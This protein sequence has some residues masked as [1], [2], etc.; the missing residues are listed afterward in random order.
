MFR[1]GSTLTEQLLAG[2]PQVEAGGE[3]DFLPRA[4]QRQLTPFPE[5]MASASRSGL[6]TLAGD[7]S[8]L[9]HRSFPQA[10][11]VTDKRPDNFLYIGLIM[12]LFLTPRSSTRPAM[13]ST[14][15]SPSTF[16][17]WIKA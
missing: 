9:L 15:A 17:I 13:P 7:Y 2:H 14:T 10:T 4:V 12:A 1:S 8:N 3:L 5:S 6:E 16:S 11:W